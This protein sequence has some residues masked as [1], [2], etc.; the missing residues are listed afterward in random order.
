MHVAFFTTTIAVDHGT[1]LCCI[2]SLAIIFCISACEEAIPDQFQAILDR[3]Q[4]QLVNAQMEK[5]KGLLVSNQSVFSMIKFDVGLT[6]LVQHRIDTKDV[7]KST[8]PN[9]TFPL[10][11]SNESSILSSEYES[12]TV[13]SFN[14]L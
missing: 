1:W 12:L 9:H 3:C 10:K 2:L 7:D 4:D 11:A 8:V 6:N 13:I 14:F 5:L